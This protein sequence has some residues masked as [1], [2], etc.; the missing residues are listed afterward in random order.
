MSKRPKNKSY[1]NLVKHCADLLIPAKLHFFCWFV[2]GIKLDIV[3]HS[4]EK[5]A[6][7]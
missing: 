2:A 7:N 4:A 5:T 1:E 6:W 3:E